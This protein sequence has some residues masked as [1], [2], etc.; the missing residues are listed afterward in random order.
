MAARKTGSVGKTG[1][2]V[3]QNP[4]P[5]VR[6]ELCC[7]GIADRRY[8]RSPVPAQDA[9]RKASCHQNPGPSVPTLPESR[10]AQRPIYRRSRIPAQGT[11]E[12]SAP[13]PAIV[14]PT[15]WEDGNHR[16][17]VLP[18]HRRPRHHRKGPRNEHCWREG[19]CIRIL[20]VR[21][22]EFPSRASRPVIPDETLLF[23]DAEKRSS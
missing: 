1:T 7:A 10:A 21:R 19:L 9:A 8:R 17:A 22:L 18:R 20:Q 2:A 16:D 14:V 4:G 3:R 15:P 23:F 6:R 12:R 11:A 13:P 5:S